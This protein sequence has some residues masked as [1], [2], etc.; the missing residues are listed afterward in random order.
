MNEYTSE[1]PQ[2]P[3]PDWTTAPEWANWWAIDK[4]GETAWYEKAPY[5]HP[6]DAGW[7]SQGIG[8]EDAERTSLPPGCKWHMT[9]RQRPIKEEAADASTA[10][11]S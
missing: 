10:Q 7:S 9:L 2:Y 6:G 8:W 11:A 5:I 4:D 1:Q 3:E